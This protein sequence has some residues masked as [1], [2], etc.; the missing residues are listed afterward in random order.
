MPPEEIMDMLDGLEYMHDRSGKQYDKV[1]FDIDS[2]ENDSHI[3]GQLSLSAVE[4]DDDEKLVREIVLHIWNNQLLEFSNK[5]VKDNFN[6][7]YDKA[8]IVMQRLEALEI[9]T[10]LKAKK[11]RTVDLVK[12]QEFLQRNEHEEDQS[13]VLSS[14]SSDTGT[15]TDTGA[16]LD[17]DTDTSTET[18]A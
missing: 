7:G 6:M 11:R 14:L 17:V 1:F 15:N 18:G 12:V 4:D 8:N 2:I 10:K 13:V 9:V 5:Q 16:A 3:E